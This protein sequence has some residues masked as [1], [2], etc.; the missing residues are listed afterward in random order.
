MRGRSCPLALGSQDPRQNFINPIEI[1]CLLV[2]LTPFHKRGDPGNICGWLR[3]CKY[4]SP[5]SHDHLVKDTATSNAVV[6]LYFF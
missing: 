4:A 2:F 6:F 3:P 1:Y 5:E